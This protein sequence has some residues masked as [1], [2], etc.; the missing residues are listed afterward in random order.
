MVPVVPR[1]LLAGQLV[2]PASSAFAM[3][4]L[5]LRV[6]FRGGLVLSLVILRLLSPLHQFF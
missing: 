5:Q 4:R 1:P 3:V 2:P 6:P